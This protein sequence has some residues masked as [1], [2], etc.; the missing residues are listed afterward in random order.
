[1]ARQGRV[2]YCGRAAAVN[3][4]RRFAGD[5]TTSFNVGDSL[6]GTGNNGET[7]MATADHT[8]KEKKMSKTVNIVC[9]LKVDDDLDK[10]EVMQE[11][12]SSLDYHSKSDY[13]RDRWYLV[14]HKGVNT[15]DEETYENLK[16]VDSDDMMVC[17]VPKV[18][19]THDNGTTQFR[20]NMT[21]PVLRDIDMKP[22]G[23]DM[24]VSFNNRVKKDGRTLF[25]VRSDGP[26]T[27]GLL[28]HPSEVGDAENDDVWEDKEADHWV[29]TVT[30]KVDSVDPTTYRWFDNK[31]I[32]KVKQGMATHDWVQRTRVMDCSKEMTEEGACYDMF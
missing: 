31:V 3:S 19:K 12:D 21:K 10:R 1:M 28:K 22:P 14:T 18:K 30:C 32:P 23:S 4:G 24:R 26:S 15:I 29:V 17:H 2:C 7:T 16:D 25:R 8:T 5:D 6:S 27:M 9:Y 11:L 20:S 13:K